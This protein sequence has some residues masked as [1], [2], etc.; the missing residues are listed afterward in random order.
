[1]VLVVAVWVSMEHPLVYSSSPHHIIRHI[2]VSWNTYDVEPRMEDLVKCVE[3]EEAHIVH[4]R[5]TNHQ[6][7]NRYRLTELL[8]Q[9]LN[10]TWDSRQGDSGLPLITL[11][12][13]SVLDLKFAGNVAR[14]TGTYAG[15]ALRYGALLC[16]FGVVDR[17]SRTWTYVQGRPKVYE[18]LIY[19]SVKVHSHR[20]R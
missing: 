5:V 19:L 3:R 1:M 10:T 8:G 2:S 16:E 7:V 18:R 14:P 6:I 11:W 13:R 12:D 4:I 17:S 20:S 15:I 9:A